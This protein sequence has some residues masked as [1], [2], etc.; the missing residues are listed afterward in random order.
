MLVSGQIILMQWTV[1]IPSSLQYLAVKQEATKIQQS[2]YSTSFLSRS[3]NHKKGISIQ[4]CVPAIQH[5]AIIIQNHKSLQLNVV[6]I[7]HFTVEH[8][9]STVH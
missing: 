6:S 5:K 9:L 4:N 2:L 8:V 3:C 7:L 1:W